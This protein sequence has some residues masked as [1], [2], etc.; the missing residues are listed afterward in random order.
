[1][2]FIVFDLELNQ[3]FSSLQK[4]SE[5][6]RSLCPFEIIQIGAVKL[7]HEL[8]TLA[9]FD[10][11]IKPSIY[12][13]IN[14][15]ITELTG[16]TTSQLQSEE[17]FSQVYEAFSE[18][19]SGSDPVF[20]SWGMSDIKELFS[21]VEEHG[22]S[23]KPL[24]RKFINLQPYVSLFFNY[25]TRNLLR[26]EYAVKAFNLPVIHSFHNAF[27]DAYYTAEI[28]RKIYNPFIQPKIY[29]SSFKITRPRQPK[30]TIDTNGLINQ[31]EKMYDRKMT[32]EEQSII[33]LAY[34]M[35][36]TN[37]FLK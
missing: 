35:G 25:S 34:K 8:K 4:K 1:M 31:F 11:Y 18:F 7:D 27:G 30:R 29:D 16:I 32:A 23:S 17:P 10:R 12:E 19:I 36:K 26:L 15:F 22:L 6:K 9:A 28:F 5:G 37:Q 24:P 21:N 13:K 3:D 2:S 20:C 33:L 14:P